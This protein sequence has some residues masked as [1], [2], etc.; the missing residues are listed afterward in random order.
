[1][2]IV[3]HHNNSVSR[4]VGAPDCILDQQDNRSITQTVLK[5]AQRYPTEKIVWCCEKLAPNLNIVKIKSLCHH[6]MMLLTYSLDRS[7]FLQNQI[8][9]VEQ[10]P[11]INVNKKVQYPTWLMSTD[12]GVIDA[13]ILNIFV[14]KIKADRDFEYFLNSIAKLGMPKGLFCYSEPQLLVAPVTHNLE[15]KL[16]Y[17]TLFRFVKQHYKKR[18]LFISLLNFIVFEKRF[19]LFPFLKAFF[20]ST[21]RGVEINFDSLQVQSV[22]E[23]IKKPTIDVVIPT[24]GRKAYLYDVLKDLASQ[25][26]LPVNVIIVEQNQESG[27]VSELDYLTAE[28]WPFDIKHT[29]THQTGACQARNIALN[30]V[31]SD[32]V[33]L[34]DDD[35]RF[36]ATLIEEMFV[37]AKQYRVSVV[38]TNYL[39]KGEIQEYNLVHQSGIFGSGN[40]FVQSDVLTNLRFDTALEHGYGEDTAFGL[41]L[42]NL[43]H[44]VI[45]FPSLKITHLKA[46]IG[47]FRTPFKHPWE[48]EKVQPKPSPTIM[49]VLLKY[50]TAQQLKGYKVVLFL[51]MVKKESLLNVISFRKEFQIKWE[52]SLYW[53]KK[54]KP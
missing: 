16:N 15:K 12:V 32:W 25:T 14:S 10:S 3:Y 37:K 44:D 6:Q 38:T 39:I 31:S 48:S 7:I 33:F 51:K 13:V 47:G 19:P 29:F 30:Q 40:S 41:Q 20:F 17:F 43:G 24:M 9:Y 54:L 1:M 8:G 23:Q 4:V 28:E 52:A 27:S 53:A 2:I 26:H 11:F 49:Y 18:W 45:Y 46:P 35:N 21:R 42:R 34:A 36:V 5:L 50:F 22:E